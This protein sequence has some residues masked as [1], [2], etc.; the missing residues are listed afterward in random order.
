MKK[1][2][3]SLA[4]SEMQIQTTLDSTSPQSEW[5]SRKRMATNAGEDVGESNTYTLL[6]GM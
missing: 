1:C 4:I 6:M 3:I 2:S 5:I